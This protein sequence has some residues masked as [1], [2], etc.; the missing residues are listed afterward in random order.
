MIRDNVAHFVATAL[1]FAFILCAVTISSPPCA[2][3]TFEDLPTPTKQSDRVSSLIEKLDSGNF[4][5]RESASAELAKLGKEAIGPLAYHSLEC[6]PETVWRIKKT[7]ESICTNGDRD[8]FIK[9]LGILQL[10][11]DTG[12][13]NSEM[14]IRFGQLKHEWQ[15]RR[16]EIA[17]SK[18]EKHGAIITDPWK[19]SGMQRFGAPALGGGPFFRGGTTV[20]IDGIPFELVDGELRPFTAR[21]QATVRRKMNVLSTKAQRE[22]IQTILSSSVEE[23]EE[24]VFGKP[25][26]KNQKS[27]NQK[28]NRASDPFSAPLTFSIGNPTASSLPGVTVEIP[29]TWD[30][31]P[32][33]LVELNKIAKLSELTLVG[34]TINNEAFKQLATLSE[35]GTL[36]LKD[37]KI[38]AKDA[39]WNSSSIQHLIIANQ[40]ISLEL[41]TSLRTVLSLQT[42][43]FNECKINKGALKG[44]KKLDSLRGLTFTKMVLE[45]SFFEAITKQE[46]LTFANFSI[47]R[48][49]SGQFKRLT[50]KRPRLQ[51]DYSGQ[52]LLGVHGQQDLHLSPTNTQG[53]TGSIITEVVPGSAADVSGMQAGD[54]LQQVDKT[55]ISNFEDLRICIA[56]HQ[57]GD[58]LVFKAKRGEKTVTLKVKLGKAEGVE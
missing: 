8:L 42:L 27:K 54:I 3:A 15:I 20:T 36:T 57:P 40:N 34:Q 45:D 50:A 49:D 43:T 10:R 6:S 7:L 47:C 37:C 55:K 56:G 21:K 17:V 28:K 30:G 46:K 38:E 5:D 26:I 53:I 11:F 24:L 23:N 2:A 52:A 12:A 44:L 33:D 35:L 41:L 31:K 25:K 51:I 13:A 9:S 39:R 18:L 14:Q 16:K 58:E 48:F 19:D 32:E 22:K 29:P 4:A 1:L